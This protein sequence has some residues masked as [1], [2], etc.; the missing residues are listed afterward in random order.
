MVK[1]IFCNNLGACKTVHYT[2]AADYV[3]TTTYQSLGL[4]HLI[5]LVYLLPL[6]WSHGHF[7]K[8]IGS[9]AEI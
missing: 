4:C 8:N 3:L 9:L 5:G 2:N 7:D 1:M 6:S